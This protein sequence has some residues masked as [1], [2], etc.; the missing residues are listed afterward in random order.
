MNKPLGLTVSDREGEDFPRSLTS[1]KQGIGSVLG[2]GLLDGRT[3]CVLL[4]PSGGRAP[5]VRQGE[6]SQVADALPSRIFPAPLIRLSPLKA[7]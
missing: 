6:L 4:V 2:L 5:R 1:E 3:C 7:R